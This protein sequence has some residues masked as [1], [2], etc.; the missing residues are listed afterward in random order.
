MKLRSFLL[1]GIV[2]AAV[3]GSG[4]CGREARDA[5]GGTPL[6]R[7]AERGDLAR[8]RHLLLDRAE[9]EA[10]DRCHWTPLMKAA[11]NGHA[12]VVDTLLA[13]GALTE[14]R[15]RAGYTALMLAAQNGHVPAITR[16]LAAGAWIEAREPFRDTTA[17]MLAARGGH[18]AAVEA[19]LAAGADPAATDRAGLRA[20]GHALEAGHPQLAQ[21]LAD[22]GSQRH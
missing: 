13:G 2:L 1:S 18:A 17:L 7:A 12:E 4:G 20:A 10:V 5:E 19:L 16:L 6:L 8:V 9:P 14:T 3:A 15:D 22:A 21:R 11:L